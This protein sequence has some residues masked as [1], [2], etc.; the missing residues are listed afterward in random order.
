MMT[1][2]LMTLMIIMTAVTTS[3]L[4]D[5]GAL[6]APRRYERQGQADEVTA[7]TAGHGSDGALR[8]NASTC[9]QSLRCAPLVIDSAMHVVG[10]SE[11]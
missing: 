6:G 5:T 10:L 11:R 4:D 7:P 1:K 2:K 8:R 3:E 9:L